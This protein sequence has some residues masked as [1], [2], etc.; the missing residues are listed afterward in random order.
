MFGP[1]YGTLGTAPA[2][3]DVCVAQ[4]VLR[5]PTNHNTF[6]PLFLGMR[7]CEIEQIQ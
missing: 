4:P 5:I 2:G 7:S 1:R 6:T 3:R